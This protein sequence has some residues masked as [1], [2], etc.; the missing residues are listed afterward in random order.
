MSTY[1][2]DE[3]DRL[4]PTGRRGA[5]RR[6]DGIGRRGAYVLIAVVAVVAILLVVGV[7]NIIR[8]SFSDPEEQVAPPAV[9]QTESPDEDP[10]E[11]ADDSVAAV[12]REAVVVAVFNGSGVTGAGAAFAEAT[13]ANGWIVDEVGNYQTPDPSSTVYYSTADQ[14]V[15]AAALAEELG[16]EQIEESGDF[17]ADLTVVV[18]SDIAE[19]GPPDAGGGTA[20]P[21]EGADG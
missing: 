16:I 10:T 13:E 4:P 5:H 6:D 14:E 15:Q 2:E 1:P 11:D 19:Q 21:E 12:D 20:A 9:E 8:T 18:A 17:S 7:F 3:F